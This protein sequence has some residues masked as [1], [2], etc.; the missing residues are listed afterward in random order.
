M[1]PNPKPDVYIRPVREILELLSTTTE[2]APRAAPRGRV[3][4]QR[5]MLEPADLDALRR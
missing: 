4:R 5:T 2:E 1:N 3:D